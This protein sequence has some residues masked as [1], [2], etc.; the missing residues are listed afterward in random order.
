[1][2]INLFMYIHSYIYIYTYSYRYM[3]VYIYIFF[4]IIYI[5]CVNI[6]T[7]RPYE[8]CKNNWGLAPPRCPFEAGTTVVQIISTRQISAWRKWGSQ[9]C[10]VIKAVPHDLARRIRFWR[11]KSLEQDFKYLYCKISKI[12][13]LNL[14]NWKGI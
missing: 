5:I 12:L 3:Y 1:M 9:L 14:F 10:W 11:I 8:S 4:Y 2:Y 6:Y 13:L 7:A